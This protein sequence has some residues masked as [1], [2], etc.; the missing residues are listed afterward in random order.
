M[1]RRRAE[2]EEQ[3]PLAILFARVEG[4][5]EASFMLEM[6][7]AGKVCGR[8]KAKVRLPESCRPE[9]MTEKELTMRFFRAAIEKLEMEFDKEIDDA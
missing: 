8:A 6:R 4:W 7:V 2:E 1:P 3:H 9:E 5:P